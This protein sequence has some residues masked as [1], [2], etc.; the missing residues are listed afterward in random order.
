M[1]NAVLDVVVIGAGHAGLTAS[2]ILTQK[3]LK[4]LVLERGRIGASWRTQRWDSFVMNTGYA[5][6]QLPENE[7][8]P[9]KN[10]FVTAPEFAHAPEKDTAGLPDQDAACGSPVSSLHLH[11]DQVGAII[12]T[13]G[14]SADF[15]YIKLPVFDIDGNPEHLDGVAV[16]EGLYF[17]GLPW[18]RSM[19][20]ALINGTKDDAAFIVEKVYAFA[21]QY[22]LNPV[23]Q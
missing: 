23:D 15:S 9:R 11:Y 7:D 6:H 1:E 16:T 4:H 2:Y 20:S 5:C 8:E 22:Y 17:L 10:E 3:R 18:L 19:K 21:R 12:W 14:F 13:T